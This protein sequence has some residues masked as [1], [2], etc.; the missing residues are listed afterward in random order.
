MS[1]IVFYDTEFTTWEGAMENDWK[2]PG[3]YRELVQIGAIRFDLETLEEQEEFLV[4]VRP[5]KNPVLSD[6][7]TQLTGIT[8]AEVA[9][10]GLAFPDA[11]R[12]FKAFIGNEQTSCYGWDARVM[13]EN[14]VFNNMPATEAEFDSHNIGPWFFDAGAAYGVIKGKTNSGK[15]AATVGAPMTSIQEHNALHDARSIAAAYRFLIGKGSKSPFEAAA[16][17]RHARP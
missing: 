5:V 4:L 10:D 2:E 7:F 1:M 14:L 13:R 12:Q 15:L 11:Y 3:Q 8:N 9:K 16:P 6:F 17:A